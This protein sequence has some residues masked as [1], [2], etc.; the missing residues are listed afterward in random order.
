MDYVDICP[1]AIVERIQQA[2]LGS[3]E[4]GTLMTWIA[5]QGNFDCTVASVI[6]IGER[7]SS[8]SDPAVIADFC[9]SVASYA[10]SFDR[11]QLAVIRAAY[12]RFPYHPSI[13]LPYF[14]GLR[15]TGIDIRD[16]LRLKVRIDWNFVHPRQNAPTWHYFMYLAALGEPGALDDLAAKIAATDNGNDAT[17][18]LES[19]AELQAPGVDEIL[20]RYAG[21]PRRAD[22]T[23]EPGM[24]ISEN[25]KLWLMMRGAE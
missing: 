11:G 4:A 21:D 25:V 22:G 20:R 14:L 19:L 16:H 6:A 5:S 2:D 17:N 23:E 18:L 15:A 1:V 12:L 10:G 7:M 3:S 9:G 24:P 13:A 8:R